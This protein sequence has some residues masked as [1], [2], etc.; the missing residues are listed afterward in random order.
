LIHFFCTKSGSISSHFRLRYDENGQ[1][2]Y[3]SHWVRILSSDNV[4]KYDWQIVNAMFSCYCEECFKWNLKISVCVIHLN[5]CSIIIFKKR[6]WSP[7]MSEFHKVF[8][9]IRKCFDMMIPLLD[10]KIDNWSALLNKIHLYFSWNTEFSFNSIHQFMYVFYLNYIELHLDETSLIL[11]YIRN[12]SPWICEPIVD[13]FDD[14]RK[15]SCL[16]FRRIRNPFW[17]SHLWIRTSFVHS[18]VHTY[19]ISETR[20]T[21]S[22]N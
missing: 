14:G 10:K 15:Y 1:L 17:V 22:E 9:S 21:L 13:T 6:M 11:S 16:T 19:L 8:Y 4:S 7:K 20:H 2:L 18:L 3:Y 5:S 12:T